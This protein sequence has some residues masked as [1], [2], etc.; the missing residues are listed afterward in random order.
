MNNYFFTFGSGQKYYGGYHKIE[1]VDEDTARLFMTK[2]FGPKW[3]MMYRTAADAGVDK[4]QLVEITVERL[5]KDLR[6]EKE[7]L[8]RR[9]ADVV[10][11]T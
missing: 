11:T 5:L 4:F 9:I 10:S 1:A 6:E 8:E 3:S 2:R 7:K